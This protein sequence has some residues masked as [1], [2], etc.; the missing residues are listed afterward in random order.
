MEFDQSDPEDYNQRISRHNEWHIKARI[1]K[2]NTTQGIPKYI[3]L[4]T[5]N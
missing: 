5:K 2:R 3:P 4:N 1:Q